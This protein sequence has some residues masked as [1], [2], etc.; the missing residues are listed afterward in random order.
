MNSIAISVPGFLPE[1][2]IMFSARSTI[3]TG[4]PMSST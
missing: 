3:R 4:S 2:R 1:S